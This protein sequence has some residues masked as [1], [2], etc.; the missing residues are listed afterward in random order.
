[1]G[2][3][4]CA[5]VSMGVHPWVCMGVHGWAWVCMAVHGCAWVCM[6]V[7]GCAWMCMHGCACAIA[8][9][10]AWVC[11]G[12]IGC[13]C[14]GVLGCAWAWNGATVKR[15]ESGIMGRAW[16]GWGGG[17]GGAKQGNT[18]IANEHAFFRRLLAYPPAA[19]PRPS[20]ACPSRMGYLPKYDVAAADPSS[21]WLPARQPSFSCGFI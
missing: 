4:G 2:V 19:S 5:W 17:V 1:M 6:G 11:T 8:H 7:H 18:P 21:F 15:V 3:H 20:R 9:G 10:C 14:M 12:D 16:M 13:A